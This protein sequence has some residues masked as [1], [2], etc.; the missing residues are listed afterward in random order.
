MGEDIANHISD[1]G[2]ISKVCKELIHLNNKKTNSPIKKWGKDLNRHFSKEDIQIDNRHM[3]RC[4]TSLIIRETQ[5]KTTIRYHLMLIRMPIINKTGNNMWW[6]G[7]GERGT[8]IHCWW[9]CKLVQPLWKTILRFLR[10]LRIELPYNPA[11]P[12]LG[13]YPKSMK[14]QMPNDTCTPMFIAALFIITKTW[15]QPRC[16]SRDEWIK[17]V[18]YIY[19]VECYSAIRNDEIWPFVTTWMDL[20]GIMLSEIIQRE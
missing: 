15:K 5:V 16:P 2:L 20:E 13:I 7:C 19:T 6:R 9:E 12:L 17:N 3:K 8:L 10:K 18:W 1:K 14:I 11:I 4:S